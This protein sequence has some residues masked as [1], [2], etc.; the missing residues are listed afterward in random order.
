[1][2][3]N[4]REKIIQAAL[5]SFATRGYEGTTLAQISGVV[6]LQKPSLYNHF[7][8]KAALFLT[9][10]EKVL[11]EMLEVMKDSWEKHKDEHIDKR[12]YLVLT[13]ST[14]FTIREHEGMIYRR[15]LLFPPPELEGDLQAL[16]QFGDQAIDQ[17]L[18]EIY[19]QAEREEA[20]R[21][22]CFSVFRASFYC[23]MDGLFTES[24]IYGGDEFRERFDGSWDVFWRGIAAG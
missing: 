1:M 12:L 8:G 21:D 13:E 4:T 17:L 14:S 11:G 6:G 18:R 5:S 2:A 10:A 3:T 19:E 7:S 20:I 22:V 23:L 15:L 9:V 24:I 16:V